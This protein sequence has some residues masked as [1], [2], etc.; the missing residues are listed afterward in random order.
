MDKLSELIRSEARLKYIEEQ[1]K[2]FEKQALEERKEIKKIIDSLRPS[3]KEQNEDYVF[4]GPL[5]WPADYL[6]GV[7]SDPVPV[8]VP[9]SVPKPEPGP[10]PN[11]EKFYVCDCC[12]NEIKDI[13]WHTDNMLLN[14]DLCDRCYNICVRNDAKYIVNSK[15]RICVTDLRKILMTKN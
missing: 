13:R 3:E 6:I 7:T 14:F 15:H 8:S 5:A 11:L 2:Y 12:Y 10:G 4:T 9:V 1:C